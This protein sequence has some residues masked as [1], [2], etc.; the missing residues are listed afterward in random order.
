VARA[1]STRPSP[2]SADDGDWDR[3]AQA[4]IRKEEVRVYYLQGIVAPGETPAPLDTRR[5]KLTS[6]AGVAVQINN[7]M[8]SVM[9]ENPIRRQVTHMRRAWVTEITFFG[10]PPPKAA[11]A[12]APVTANA[13]PPPPPPRIP[14]P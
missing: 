9:V 4:V 10:W 2:L 12:P 14:R 3:F 5:G 7:Q 6:V 8:I 11:A 1:I 13:V